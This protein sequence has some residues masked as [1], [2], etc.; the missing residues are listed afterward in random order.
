MLRVLYHE[1]LKLVYDVCLSSQ[2][3]LAN[4]IGKES[5]RG[6]RMKS[7]E[8]PGESGIMLVHSELRH[9]SLLYQLTKSA[10]FSI[11]SPEYTLLVYVKS[12]WMIVMKNSL[13][14]HRSVFPSPSSS[15]NISAISSST[16]AAFS[17][18]EL[19]PMLQASLLWSCIVRGKVPSELGKMQI[20]CTCAYSYS[21][22]WLSPRELNGFIAFNT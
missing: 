20:I 18:L 7:I 8:M 6:R 4:Y 3:K 2:Y 1:D 14:N 22:S 17:A 10:H 21:E 19:T 13:R 5:V 11:F 16:P 9:T 12:I 15:L